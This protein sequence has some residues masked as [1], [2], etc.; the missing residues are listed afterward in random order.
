MM[1]LKY[2]QSTPT[3]CSVMTHYVQFE[4]SSRTDR[5]YN[6][7]TVC[8]FPLKGVLMAKRPVKVQLSFSYWILNYPNTC[9]LPTVDI[10]FKGCEASMSEVYILHCPPL[11]KNIISPIAKWNFFRNF[12]FLMGVLPHVLPCQSW[13]KS[14]QKYK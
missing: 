13:P 14:T 10:T 3:V 5:H 12:L 8:N 11:C 9:F 4:I 7:P 6:L 2:V 1:C